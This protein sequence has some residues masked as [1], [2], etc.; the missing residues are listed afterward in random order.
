[1]SLATAADQD[2]TARHIAG[3]LPEMVALRRDI[4]RHPELGYQEQRTS[5]LVAAALAGWG[6]EVHRGLGGTG[7]VGTLRAGSGSKVLGIRADMDALPILETTGLDYASQHPGRMHA[8]GHDGHTT[9]LLTAARCLAETRAFDGTL[10]LIF[11]PAEEGLGGALKMMQDGLFELFPC[12]QVFGLHNMPGVPTGKF[13][14]VDGAAMASSDTAL[15]RIRGQGGHGAVPDKAVDPIVASAATVMA[16]QTVV[17]RN[18]APLDTAVVTVGSIHGG[19]ASNV[20][21][22]AVEMKLTIRAFQDSTR[23][24]LEQR[25]GALVRAQAE[26]F[27]ATAELD[28]QRGYPVLVNHEGPTAFARQVAVDHFGADAL[29]PF[30]PIPASEDFAY[31]LQQ[32]PGCY[33]F[34]GNGPSANLHNAAYDFNDALLPVGAR[35]WVKL[36]EAFLTA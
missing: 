32:V 16:L 21:P 6:Y 4:H 9:T 11:Q 30:A 18:V 15:L 28:Y 25:I 26:S 22:D 14:F 24:L 5:D 19:E 34:V 10:H 8:C 20:I 27:G 17:S 1:M 29:H 3:Y 12:D 23:D 36:T 7:V 35:Y 2:A 31:M 33:L 13:C